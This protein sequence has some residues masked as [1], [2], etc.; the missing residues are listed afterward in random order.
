MDFEL[1][2][3]L[4]VNA[5]GFRQGLE[6]AE[7]QTEQFKQKMEAASKATPLPEMSDADTKQIVDDLRKQNEATQLT[8]KSIRE[9]SAAT[10]ESGKSAQQA[11]NDFN[12]QG[13]A[14]D[15]LKERLTRTTIS[16]RD[17]GRMASQAKDALSGISPEIDKI[18]NVGEAFAKGG[19]IAGLSSIITQSTASIKDSIK[20]Y[21]AQIDEAK[22]K[23]AE[24]AVT[25]TEAF[26]RVET[27]NRVW[28]D[29]VKYENDKAFAEDKARRDKV[30]QLNNVFYNDLLNSE[31]AFE[32]KQNAE[33]ARAR[34]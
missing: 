31:E 19:P 27:V 26:A 11:G 32:K 23:S 30:K 21:Y 4:T 28:R 17:L 12:K 24:E 3:T 13:D 20:D 5:E 25:T 7:Q 22:K 33:I 6:N 1:A 10:N 14:L 9:L 15:T 8:A 34:A 2:A 29:K 16:F 18:A